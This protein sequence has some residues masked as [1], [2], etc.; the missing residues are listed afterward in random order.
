MNMVKKTALAASILLAMAFTASCSS[1]D[2]DD[3]DDV[4]VKGTF[5]DSRDNQKYNTVKIG[6]QTWLAENLKYNAIGS[7]CYENLESHCDKYGRL[8][9]WETADTACPAGWHLSTKGEWDV[10]SVSAGGENVAGKHLKAASGWPAGANGLDKYGFAA[11]PG[12]LRYYAGGNFSNE[13]TMGMWWTAS[14]INGDAYYRRFDYDGIATWASYGKEF[15][16]SVR[17]VQGI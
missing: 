11:L 13:G 12:G 9:I 6:N 8:Y 14:E 10:L 15:L 5:T 16:F 3:G 1:S 2:D 17:C 4:I 7:E